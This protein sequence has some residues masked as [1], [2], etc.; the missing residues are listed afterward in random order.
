MG[1]FTR[2]N[3]NINTPTDQKKDTPDGFWHKT[4]SGNIV[5][6]DDLEG[7]CWV[8]EEDEHHFRIGSKEYFS[9]IFDDNKFTELDKDLVSK[10]ML[11]LFTH[12]AVSF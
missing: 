7:N 6:R 12:P 9:I 5:D 1:W 4:P 3:K 11:I 2:K 8:S 10:M